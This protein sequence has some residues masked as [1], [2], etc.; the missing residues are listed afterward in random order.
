MGRPLHHRGH[1]P[2]RRR[3]L[4]PHPRARGLALPSQTRKRARDL[5]HPARRSRTGP[6]PRARQKTRTSCSTG[7]I[8]TISPPHPADHLG[9][10]HQR[11]G[12]H[13]PAFPI[14]AARTV[15]RIAQRTLRRAHHRGRQP[16]LSEN[17]RRHPQDRSRPH[18]RR[19]PRPWG[20][21]GELDKLRLP[22]GDDRIVV[23]IHCYE[24]F[25]FTHQGAGW[26]GF[27]DLRGIVYPGPPPTPYQL[28]DSLRENAGVRAFIDGYNT[29]PGDQ[30]P[31]SPRAVREP[32]MPPA[33]GR[34]ISAGPSTS[35][36]SAAT[37]PAITPAAP[38]TSATS[39]PSPK[40]ATSR[41]PSGNGKP[42]SAIGTRKTTSRNFAPAFSSEP[43]QESG[44]P[45]GRFCYRRLALFPKYQTGYL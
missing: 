2:H 1:R 33:S 8:S 17:H 13:R 43:I 3:G 20:I 23:T 10:L 41:G 27:Q 7:I 35:A 18:P 25:Q 12:S 4:R 42:A 11:L 28:P 32:S 22:D 31:C 34:T 44:K 36:N 15:L 29:L 14:M 24:P 39:E 26:V 5:P 9:T 19:Q 30:N 37:T 21:V 16:D 40:P 6:A 45:S 38:A